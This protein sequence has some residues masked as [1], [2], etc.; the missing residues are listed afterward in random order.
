MTELWSFRWRSE[1]D[2]DCRRWTNARSSGVAF[3]LWGGATIDLRFVPKL[4]VE[5]P[6]SAS[7]RRQCADAALDVVRSRELLT[8]F[9]LPALVQNASASGYLHLSQHLLKMPHPVAKII[10]LASWIP[11]SPS[12]CQWL[13]AYTASP[14]VE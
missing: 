1:E 11:I 3:P 2:G 13:T 4:Q 8:S 14:H 12:R 7:A 6:L 10:D 9:C 5:L